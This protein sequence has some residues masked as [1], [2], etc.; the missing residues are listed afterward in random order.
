MVVQRLAPICL[1]VYNRISEV[2]RTIEALENNFLAGESDLY[3]F[4]DEGRDKEDVQKVRKVRSY[5][6]TISG[7]NSITIFEAENNKG[8]AN[9]VISGVSKVLENHDRIVV[10]EDD[11]V[12]SPNFLDFINQSLKFYQNDHNIHSVSG[13]TLNLPSLPGKK[14]YYFGYRASSWGWGIWKERWEGID[15]D[16]CDYGKF[17]N[18]RVA[19]KSFKRGGSDLPRML[20][21]QRLGKIDSWAIRFCYHQFKNELLTVFPSESKIKSVG[22]S[23]EATNTIGTKR[24]DTQLDEGKKRSFEFGRFEKIDQILAGEAASKFSLVSRIKNRLHKILQ[25]YKG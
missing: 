10:L 14:D 24:F 21:N 2:K 12:T 8:L 17:K 22:F 5:I 15:W 9:S 18:N 20:R 4:S 11:L 19:T 25:R 7:F 6:H 16:V 1:F 3:I 13:Y 23:E